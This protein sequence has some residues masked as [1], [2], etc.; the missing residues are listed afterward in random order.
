MFI[1]YVE[2]ILLHNFLDFYVKVLRKLE[3]AFQ[4]FVA[5]SKL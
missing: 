4:N 2:V 1:Y 3:L 5:C